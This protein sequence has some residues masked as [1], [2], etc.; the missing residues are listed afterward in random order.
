MYN[1]T[2]QGRE[3][4]LCEI[5]F[6]R[7]MRLISHQSEMCVTP[8]Y[9]GFQKINW[10][11]SQFPI[12]LPIAHVKEY[13]LYYHLSTKDDPQF[14]SDVLKKCACS[15]QFIGV[16]PK[17][18]TKFAEFSDKNICHYSK[19]AG[20]C[21]PATSCVRVQDATT[22]LARHMWE[23]FKLTPIDASVIYQIPWIRRIQCKFC[24]I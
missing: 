7:D 17:C 6:P 13:N 9:F 24:S 23:I 4:S 15:S 2:S 14:E 10:S 20:T 19:R 8:W 5:K 1:F 16:F 12:T 22:V 18:L 11:H 3:I 21:H